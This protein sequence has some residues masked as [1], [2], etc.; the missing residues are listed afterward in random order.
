[1]RCL[2]VPQQVLSA[3]KSHAFC[4]CEF[5]SKAGNRC[6]VRRALDRL[7]HDLVLRCTI[8]IHNL[9]VRGAKTIKQHTVW[10]CL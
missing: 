3:L 5:L 6:H 8:Q 9:D 10:Q 2:E 4:D 1:M 7:Q